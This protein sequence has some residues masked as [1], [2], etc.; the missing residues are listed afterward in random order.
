MAQYAEE[1]SCITQ[2]E[3]GEMFE[4]NDRARDYPSHV[5]LA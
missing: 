1:R 5:V 3:L 4:K 2:F